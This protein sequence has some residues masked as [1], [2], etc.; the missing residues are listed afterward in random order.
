MQGYVIRLKKVR[1]SRVCIIVAN[2]SNVARE[3]Q[4]QN[5]E[6]RPIRGLITFIPV[7]GKK[8]LCLGYILCNPG[9]MLHA[10]PATA[11][12]SLA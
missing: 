1:T 3:R 5:L 2:F 7:L 8:S 6:R 11:G 12:G 10:V 9:F 4:P